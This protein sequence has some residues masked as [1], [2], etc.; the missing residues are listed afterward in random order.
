MEYFVLD[1]V[2]AGFVKRI[3]AFDIGFDLVI[4]VGAHVYGRAFMTS[5]AARGRRAELQGEGGNHLMRAFAQRDQHAAGLGS[6]PGLAQQLA[7]AI[8]ALRIRGEEHDGIR[9]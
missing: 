4:A 2:A 9:G 6:I 8:I 5:D 7:F 3:A 1:G